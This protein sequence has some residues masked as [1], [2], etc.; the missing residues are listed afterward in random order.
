MNKNIILKKYTVYCIRTV[1]GIEYYIFGIII[2]YIFYEIQ[3]K[4]RIFMHY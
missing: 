3:V 4:R 1:F 2:I